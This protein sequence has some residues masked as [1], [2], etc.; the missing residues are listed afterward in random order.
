MKSSYIFFIQQDL[1]ML[2]FWMYP[3]LVIVTILLSSLG[4]KHIAA[5]HK[6]KKSVQT[7]NTRSWNSLL[8]LLLET[9][10]LS[11]QLAAKTKQKNWKFLDNNFQSSFNLNDAFKLRALTRRTCVKFEEANRVCTINTLVI[12]K[13]PV[14]KDPLCKHVIQIS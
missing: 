5:E 8:P 14:F 11:L 12:F 1:I 6:G 2:F 3:K 7:S 13:V 10:R 9:F 4:V